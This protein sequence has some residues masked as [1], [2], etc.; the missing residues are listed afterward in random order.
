[1]EYLETVKC[2]LFL[3]QCT[4]FLGLLLVRLEDG[5]ENRDKDARED[6]AQC[7]SNNIGKAGACCETIGKRKANK[8]SRIITW[9]QDGCRSS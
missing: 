1:M 7:T 4:L 2:T 6:D 9:K 8:P 3:G 5:A